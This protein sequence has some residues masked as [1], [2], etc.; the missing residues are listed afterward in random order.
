M[1]ARALLAL[2]IA[3]MLPPTGAA[4]QSAIPVPSA[5]GEKRPR[6]V[7]HPRDRDG[8]ALALYTG[9]LVEGGLLSVFTEAFRWT[10]VGSQ[11]VSLI[12]SKPIDR[13]DMRVGRTHF[14]G[15]Q[16]EGEAQLIKHFGAEDHVEATLT[17]MF[18][19]GEVRLGRGGASFNL[20]VANGLSYAFT[21]PKWEYGPTHQRGVNAPQILWYIGL[22]AELSH[23]AWKG[24]SGFARIHHRS[25][26][27][28]ALGPDWYWSNRVGLGLR[29]RFE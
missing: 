3:G 17:L 20:A 6:L 18:R 15:W 5:S 24:L 13:W 1:I 4:A 21:P 10:F 25:E 19:T 22:E 8:L 29:Y 28:G 16:L 14:M 23:T 11:M 12:V 2:L 26:V 7:T 9:G 27:Y